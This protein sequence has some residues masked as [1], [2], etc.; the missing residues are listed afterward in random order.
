[1][2]TR[3]KLHELGFNTKYSGFELLYEAIKLAT[4]EEDIRIGEIYQRLANTH[5]S[6]WTKVER[7]IRTCIQLSNSNYKNNK[8]SEVIYELATIYKNNYDEKNSKIKF[9]KVSY[10]QFCKDMLTSSFYFT[11]KEIKKIYDDIQLPTRATKGSAGYDF[12]APFDLKFVNRMSEK[13]PTGIRCEMDEDVVLVLVPRSSLGFKYR[14][15]LDN[16]IAVIDSDYFHAKNEGHIQCK[17]HYDNDNVEELTINKGTAYMQGIFIKYL[18]TDDDNS[19]ELRSGGIGS[20]T[21]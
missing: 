15:A 18:K 11:D 10:Q 14:M 3:K 21:K 1:M 6:S 12:Y 20:T 5:N 13:F 16:T 9:Y 17:M 8:C 2:I 4:N 19:T 7:N